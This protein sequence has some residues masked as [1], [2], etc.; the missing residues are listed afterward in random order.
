MEFDMTLDAR[1]WQ[2]I[3]SPSAAE[4]AAAFR[5]PPPEYGL[6]LWWGWD[7][8][9][10]EDVIIRDLD[11]ISRRG[12]RC[13]TIEAGYGM[14]A[15]YLSPGWFKTVR[16]AIE[17]ARRRGMRVWLVDEGKYPSGFAG[18][19]FSAER[20][21]LRMQG[22]VVAE[23]IAVAPGETFSRQLS[24]ETVGALAVNP[25]DNTSH[26][27]DVCSGEL[28]WTASE[29]RWELWLVE[30]QFCTSVTR[31]VSNP[32]RGKDATN[33]LCD[34]L[35][36]AATRQFMA[37]TH[38]QYKAYLGREFGRTVLGFRGDEPDYAHMPWTPELPAE[39]ERRKGYDVRP[40]L[41]SLFAPQ[42]TD[43]AR[44]VRA[45]Y[46]DVWSDLF[47]ENFFRIQAEWC[48]SHH[49]EYLVHLNHED[50]M[51][52]LVRSEG[53]FFKAMRYVQVPGVDTI[54]NQIW[55]DKVADFPKLASSAAHLFGRPRAFGE[56][57][58]AYHIP[59]TV[60]QA[61]W[62]IDHQ[63][64]RGINLLEV[65]FYPSSASA[66][67]RSGWM[68]SDEFPRVV[69]YV[70]RAA[71]LLSMGKPTA[72][73]ALYFPTS[74]LWLGD[75]A[76][77][78]SA[79]DMARQLLEH[80]RDF[81]FADEQALASVL[82]LEGGALRNLSGQSYRA[83]VIPSV[84]AISKAALDRLR[85]FAEAGGCV[86][87]V[88]RE[89]AIIVE[90]SFLKA[91]GHADLGWA[92]REP[93]GELTPRVLEA[94]PLPDVWL[95]QPC[96]HVKALHRRWRD[97][98]LYFFFNESDQTLSREVVLAGS[99]QA[100]IWDADSGRIETLSGAHLENGRVRLPLVLAPYEARFIAITAVR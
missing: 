67:N 49:L 74:S 7:G 14:S 6:S 16:L 15:P 56:S 48:A 72:Q 58:A 61:K 31:A 26:T 78:A 80:Q 63:F 17:H 2:K 69:A 34:Y 3:V 84:S 30:R 62:V 71:Y 18:G 98:D 25:A 88:G 44:R 13:V 22:L 95:D 29:G 83:V 39:F 96:A 68:E 32:T 8:S 77:D 91:G 35:D 45:D 59:P 87:F 43:E 93:S 37:F 28:R 66:P 64:V 54:W 79:W 21:D 97:A 92:I 20:P 90:R 85:T 19:K 65:M 86:I 46:W 75:E 51:T 89:P 42:L 70:N 55:P 10:T 33:S 60:E 99:G 12:I 50:K 82:M 73:I 81:D 1:P 36:P 24:P 11:D 94:L 52:E 76:A 40:H 100:Q 41:A 53:D 47:R 5:V 38:E 4:V 9:I 23:R 57:F 27:L